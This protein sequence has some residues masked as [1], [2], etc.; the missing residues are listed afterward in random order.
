MP[1]SLSGMASAAITSTLYILLLVVT[2]E[3]GIS[4]NLVD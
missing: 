3:E 2:K 1:I 4:L